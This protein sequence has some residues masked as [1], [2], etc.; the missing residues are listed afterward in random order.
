MKKLKNIIAVILT[1]S[2]V[3]SNVF[4]SYSAV[5]TDAEN[6]KS[7]E[8]VGGY[9][10][11]EHLPQEY[12]P[13]QEMPSLKA[14]AKYDLRS[15]MP[16][17]RNQGNSGMC[18]AFATV[19]AAESNLIKKGLA[20]KSIDLSELQLAY[21]SYNRVDNPM[22]GFAGDKVII[23]S[24]DN[25]IEHGGN[26]WMSSI[27]LSKWIGLVNESLAPYDANKGASAYINWKPADS[28]SFSSNSYHLKNSYEVYFD[29]TS[30]LKSM[31]TEYG[32]AA[33]SCYFDSSYMNYNTNAFYCNGAY[34]GNHA[35]TVVG[36]D[37][38]YSRNNFNSDCRPNSNGAWIVRNSWSSSWGDNGYYY[39]SYE[40]LSFAGYGSYKYA[41]F[42][43]V[44]PVT[45]GELMYQYDGGIS[46]SIIY[47]DSQRTMYCANIYTAQSESILT[48]VGFPAAQAGI[49][50]QVLVRTDVGN[51]PNTG[52]VNGTW[53]KGKTDYSGF[54]LVDL[55]NP[56]YLSKGQRYSV[57][58]C[59][60]SSDGSE[61]DLSVDCDEDWGTLTTDVTGSAGQSFISMDAVNWLDLS[62]GQDLTLRIKAVT[63][64]VTGK[65]V[66][67]SG[68][69]RYSTASV[70][71]SYGRTSA[72]NV[73]LASGT[74]YAD[75]LCSVPYAQA[76]NAPILL[77]RGYSVDD[78]VKQTL[79]TLKT[80]NV[81][82]IGGY[83]RIS[84]NVE[85][86]LKGLGY[87][88]SRIYG[89]DRYKTCVSVAE[90][91]AEISGQPTEFAVVTGSG[92]ADAL[93]VSPYAA[94]SGMPIIY[95]PP[96]MQMETVC[97]EYLAK[98]AENGKIYIVGGRKIIRDEIETVLSGYCNEVERISGSDRY[99]TAFNVAHRF[100]SSFSNDV[101]LATGNDFPD[102]LVGGVFAARIKAPILLVDKTNNSN[103]LTGDT[104]SYIKSKMPNT[105][106]LLGG[107]KVVPDRVKAVLG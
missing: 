107:K 69:S 55:D 92:Y 18:W 42:Y 32:A 79:S 103:P 100:E 49:N 38:N 67:L 48:K 80:K 73:I 59:L 90:K 44:E 39:V 74:S 62:D 3:L 60:S 10:E 37:D 56:V 27:T 65:Y 33:V 104:V 53:Q 86:Q 23:P 58:F 89:K 82:I 17:V 101:I 47:F 29:S 30:A 76:L 36:W 43:D 97:E 102:A 16:A 75:A 81:I 77:T 34:Y 12:I 87:N 9:I 46:D 8:H 98:N 72:D 24:G 2:M 4:I 57:I 105:V 93:S 85:T 95:T 91:L 54:A 106:Y 26:M 21:F 50:Y 25:Y 15:S 68:D 78:E 71:S 6:M 52:T 61:I 31:I 20:T 70:I 45:A 94:L 41:Y 5:Q 84:E 63:I 13:P 88:V 66:R 1:L 28:L 83:G 35:V 51:E 7:L 22:G 96:T 64:P 11:P 19:A 14:A 99:V 40:D